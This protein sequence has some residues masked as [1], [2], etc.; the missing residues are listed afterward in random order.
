MAKSN[1]YT[2]T[3]D[4]GM[5]SLVGGKRVS[6]DSERLNAYGTI[7][8][9]NSWIGL[10][11]ASDALPDGQKDIL[12]FI[13]YKLFDV[14]SMLATEPESKWQ[15]QPFAS[16]DVERLEQAID[17]LDATLPPFRCFIL[18][19]GHRDAAQTHIAR[20]VARRAE[21]LIITLSRTTTVDANL[22][23]FINR[24]SDYLFVLARAIN[25]NASVDEIIWQKKR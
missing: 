24:L 13:Q 18:P 15:P 9:L 8:E 23:K 1:V 10:V 6:K 2:R 17:Q 14:C 11:A 3:G 16:E 5:T 21:R 19:G 4:A 7:D 25:I 12:L 20:T 22:A